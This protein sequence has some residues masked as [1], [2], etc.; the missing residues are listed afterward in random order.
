MCERVCTGECVRGNGS[1]HPHVDWREG[2]RESGVSDVWGELRS[3]VPNWVARDGY[4]TGTQACEQPMPGHYWEFRFTALNE[5]AFPN[6]STRGN[7]LL[8]CFPGENEL[9][10][11]V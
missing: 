1:N 8:A 11:Q 7:W 4:N 2:E 5:C 6:F 3:M 9:Y 10:V